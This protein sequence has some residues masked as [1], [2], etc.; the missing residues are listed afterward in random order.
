V[1]IARALAGGVRS[2]AAED[3]L[4][5]RYRPAV[6]RLAASFSELDS[7]EA[8]DVVQEAFVRAFRA[9]GS[10]KDRE[11]FA[12][13]LF[14]IAR[15]RAR[16]YLTSR[17]THTKAAEDATRQATLLQD[18]VPAASQALEKEAEL[19]AV[20]EV[21]DGLREGPEKETVRLFYLEG[22]LSAREIASRMGV[23]K[24]AVTMRLERFRAKIRAQLSERLAS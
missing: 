16:S 21:I 14:T 15:N 22:T 17:A 5:R 7:D 23:G 4:Y 8:E 12:A 24:S 18:H 9:L 3:E 13:W 20:R 19:K 6:A 2:K 11:R 10:L 1:L